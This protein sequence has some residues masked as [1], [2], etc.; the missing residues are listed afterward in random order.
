MSSFRFDVVELALRGVP[1]GI[2]LALEAVAADVVLLRDRVDGFAFSAIGIPEFIPSAS[3]TEVLSLATPVRVCARAVFASV[4]LQR[5]RI[6]YASPS[7]L[8]NR[9]VVH[10]HVRL[11]APVRQ[12]ASLPRVR[13]GRLE[14]GSRGDSRHEIGGID[15]RSS[16]LNAHVVH[17]GDRRGGQ[18]RGGEAP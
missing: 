2:I 18:V 10:E 12:T 1:L 7:A 16:K 14:R 11:F 6:R 9:D 8:G 3:P 17:V 5:A 13:V 15:R 4:E